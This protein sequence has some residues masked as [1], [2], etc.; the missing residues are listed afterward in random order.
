M[1]GYFHV[2]AN[3][4]SGNV[5]RLV[6]P[7]PANANALGA[8]CIGS[9]GANVLASTALPWIG[10]TCRSLATGMPAN[11]LA[12]AI[13]GFAPTSIPL[14]SLL[15]QGVPGCTQ[16]ATLDLLDMLVP[17]AGR[18]TASV[19]IPNS[20]ALVGGVFHQQVLPIELDALGNLVAVTATNALAL[21]IG[22]L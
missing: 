3:L 15:P 14:A 20:A 8:G 11:G 5:A 10:G 12:L 22:A 4:Y 7:C 18:A 19:V 9:G 16:L 21:T 17:S 6:T 2:T 13:V 1:G